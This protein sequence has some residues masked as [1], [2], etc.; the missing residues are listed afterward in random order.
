MLVFYEAGK[1]VDYIEYIRRTD[2]ESDEI[3]W[4]NGE[5]FLSIKKTAGGNADSSD[6]SSSSSTPSLTPKPTRPKPPSM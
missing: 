5:D 4:M 6:S 3:R 1:A 2:A